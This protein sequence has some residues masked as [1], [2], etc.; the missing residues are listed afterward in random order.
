MDP[1]LLKRLTS[2]DES[3]PVPNVENLIVDTVTWTEKTPL[4]GAIS[5]K[6]NIDSGPLGQKNYNIFNP[7]MQ[8]PQ[9]AQSKNTP[10]E[11]DQ[12]SDQSLPRKTDEEKF[13]GNPITTF[14][15]PDKPADVQMDSQGR[16]SL[17]TI[18]KDYA[19]YFLNM[20][21]EIS[22]N[23]QA[24]FPVFQYYQGIIRSG[25]IVVVFD[26]DREGNVSGVQV[27]KSQGYKGLDSSCVNAIEYSR[28]FGPLPKEL[29]DQE[30]I[31]VNFRFIY[32]RE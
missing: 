23:W 12:T 5:D 25:E 24:F 11:Q 3:I 16:I 19:K 9:Q 21:K 28:N 4:K 14:F 30:S 31:R 7:N 20:S 15:D 1:D 26:V 6:A 13:P 17:A 10:Q 2:T 32:V 8:P 27:V 22:H 29:Q 18:P